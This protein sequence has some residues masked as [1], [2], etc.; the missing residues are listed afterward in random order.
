MVRRQKPHYRRGFCTNE[1]TMMLI[2]VPGSRVEV[3]FLIGFAD[4]V[5][6]APGGMWSR[7]RGCSPI[8]LRGPSPA[9]EMNQSHSTWHFHSP[10]YP[11]H[12]SPP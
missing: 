6:I 1:L 11:S 7:C 10:T 9:R 4:Y 2:I 12:S 3:K 8:S 5:P